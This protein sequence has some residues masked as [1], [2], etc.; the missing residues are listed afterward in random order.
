MNVTFGIDEG[1][2]SAIGSGDGHHTTQVME[3]MH[4][5]H[6]HLSLTRMR[7]TDLHNTRESRRGRGRRASLTSARSTNDRSSIVAAV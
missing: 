7:W 3:V 5:V 4:V 1:L 2:D 6:L